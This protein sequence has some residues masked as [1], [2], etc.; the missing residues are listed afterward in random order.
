VAEERRR[1]GAHPLDGL[2]GCGADALRGVAS[3][4]AALS[5]A[6]VSVF[7]CRNAASPGPLTAAAT[8]GGSKPGTTSSF[9]SAAATEGAGSPTPSQRLSCL[10]LALPPLKLRPSDAPFLLHS[11]LLAFVTSMLAHAPSAVA[12]AQAMNAPTPTGKTSSSSSTSGGSGMVTAAAGSGVE[13]SFLPFLGS[14]DGPIACAARDV[15]W[16]TLEHLLRAVLPLRGGAVAPLQ[17]KLL[18]FVGQMVA[19]SMSAPAYAALAEPVAVVESSSSPRDLVAASAGTQDKDGVE[20]N[21]GEDDD[22]DAVRGIARVPDGFAAALGELPLLL[23]GENT[24]GGSLAVP[25]TAT[26]PSQASNSSALAFSV[27]LDVTPLPKCVPPLRPA[28]SLLLGG[29]LS[30]PSANESDEG[31]GSSNTSSWVHII[32]DNPSLALSLTFS[33][34]ES[35]GSD[36]SGLVGADTADHT[37]VKPTVAAVPFNTRDF[38]Q[39]WRHRRDT[40][41]LIPYLL[42]EQCLQF[43][44]TQGDPLSLEVYPQNAKTNPSSAQQRW[45][46][47]TDPLNNHN[48]SGLIVAGKPPNNNSNAAEPDR[49]PLVLTVALAGGNQQPLLQ[50]AALPSVDSRRGQQWH[51][52]T[53][54]DAGVRAALQGCASHSLLTGG[55]GSGSGVVSDPR[56][57]PCGTFGLPPAVLAQRAAAAA[58]AAKKNGGAGAGGGSGADNDDNLQGEVVLLQRGAATSAWSLTLNDSRCLTLRLLTNDDEPEK[59]LVVSSPLPPLTAAHVLVDL[60]PAPGPGTNGN[61]NAD[62]SSGGGDV[63]PSV[64]AASAS[65]GQ[66]SNGPSSSGSGTDNKA[67]QSTWVRVFVNGALAVHSQLPPGIVVPPTKDP[68]FLGPSPWNSGG[69]G[70]GG[71]SGGRN[72]RGPIVWHPEYHHQRNGNIDFNEEGDVATF[73]SNSQHR[74]V[75]GSIGFNKGVHEW[76]ITVQKRPCC[77]YA[78]IARNI[79]EPHNRGTQDKFHDAVSSKVATPVALLY[80]FTYLFIYSIRTLP[81]LCIFIDLDSLEGCRQSNLV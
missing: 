10:G 28:A 40:G 39:L 34:Q 54:T 65:G 33:G 41:Q 13:A 55:G 32:L 48:P 67:G 12:A 23:D 1:V 42:P 20:E 62:G 58:E 77:A 53:P 3:S 50:C 8:S 43:P 27:S 70:S 6:L 9:S 64:A 80:L 56:R 68:L 69:G 24:S 59:A 47:T 11:R 44:L 4:H 15:A 45:S 16:L 51:V 17:S 21:G 26:T 31:G 29:D 5:D 36:S 72:Q 22:G 57:A 71:G 2:S 30:S 46:L 25:L 49:K 81:L 19:Q 52:Q 7:E 37:D 74:C 63:P 79:E 60:R 78:G 73:N 76:K 66:G 75:Y 14:S 18:S 35:S 61:K 38:K